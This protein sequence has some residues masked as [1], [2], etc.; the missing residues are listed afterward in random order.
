MQDVLNYLDGRLS[1]ALGGGPALDGGRRD[2]QD[3]GEGESDAAIP[4]V[5]SA[6]TS[7]SATLILVLLVIFR[8]LSFDWGCSTGTYSVPHYTC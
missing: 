6:A 5:A 1:P 2:A 4:I 3:R 7:A 8:V